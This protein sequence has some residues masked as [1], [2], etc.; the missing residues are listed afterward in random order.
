MDLSNLQPGAIYN[1]GQVYIANPLSDRPIGY[2]SCRIRLEDGW[3]YI[4]LN[5]SDAEGPGTDVYPASQIAG[6]L[7]L[8]GPIAGPA[9]PEDARPSGEHLIL[10]PPTP[11]A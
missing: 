7:N 8:Y 3:C 6:I 9:R 11:G 2:Q 5:H 4:E 10:R 1:T